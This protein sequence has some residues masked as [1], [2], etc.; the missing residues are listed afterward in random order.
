MKINRR[1]VHYGLAYYYYPTSRSDNW[2]C[3]SM[4]SEHSGYAS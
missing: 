2:N 3:L 4:G 1:W